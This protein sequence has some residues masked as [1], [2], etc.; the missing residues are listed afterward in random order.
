MTPFAPRGPHEPRIV[1]VGRHMDR[2][3]LLAAIEGCA[4]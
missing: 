3:G 1:A 4:A 2:K